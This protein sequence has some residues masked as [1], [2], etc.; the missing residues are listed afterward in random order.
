MIRITRKFNAQVHND[1][2]WHSG[3]VRR[4][5]IR[6]H[7]SVRHKQLRPLMA[8]QRV[9]LDST[10]VHWNDIRRH[11]H[12]ITRHHRL[13]H[14]QRR[15][16]IGTSPVVIAT[17][18]L[19]MY[20]TNTITAVTIEGK[21]CVSNNVNAIAEI[22]DTI[23]ISDPGNANATLMNIGIC[24]QNSAWT[25]TLASTGYQNTCTLSLNPANFGIT[26]NSSTPWGYSVKISPRYEYMSSGGNY[27]PNVTFPTNSSV[28]CIYGY[29]ALVSRQTRTITRFFL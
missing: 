18:T 7:R 21:S 25:W 24:M 22:Q 16:Q 15:A 11:Q 19:P 12:P 17:I 10:M 13:C 20:N 9:S 27:M 26:M 6:H 29:Q 2:A 1:I 28:N 5:R 4:R 8:Q 3:I 14:Q 23:R